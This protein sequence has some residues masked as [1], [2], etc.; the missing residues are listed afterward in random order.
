MRLVLE[1]KPEV[2]ERIRKEAE[3]RGMDAGEYAQ[4]LLERL[5]PAVEQPPSLWETLTPEEWKREFDAWVQS[6][7]RS[8]PLLSD[9]AVSRESFYEG[10]P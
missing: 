1:L 6:H 8:I 10:R 4:D 7:D 2:E 5:L 3:Q 9:E